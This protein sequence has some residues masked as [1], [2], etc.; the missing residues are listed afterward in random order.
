[1]EHLERLNFETEEESRTL[2]QRPP[3]RHG[4]GSDILRWL[5][6]TRGARLIVVMRSSNSN[7]SRLLSPQSYSE[8]VGQSFEMNHPFTRC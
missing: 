1:V 6:R 8:T 3:I 7:S 2:R 5:S 4:I